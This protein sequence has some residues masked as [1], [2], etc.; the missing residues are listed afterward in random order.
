[1]PAPDPTEAFAWTAERGI[2]PGAVGVPVRQITA[3]WNSP[4]VH[5]ALLQ[6]GIGRRAGRLHAQVQGAAAERRD[7]GV[8]LLRR[9]TD[10]TWKSRWTDVVDVKDLHL[11]DLIRQAEKHHRDRKTA[12]LPGDDSSGDRGALCQEYNRAPRACTSL[13]TYTPIMTCCHD[14]DIHNRIPRFPEAIICDLVSDIV[15]V[16]RSTSV[17]VEHQHQTTTSNHEELARTTNT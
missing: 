15:S 3:D 8:H 2:Q 9:I 5:E 11:A 7:A 12:P 4:V 1:M 13:E 10:V 14:E 16:P 17:S 6:K